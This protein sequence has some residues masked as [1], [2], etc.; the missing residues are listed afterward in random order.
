MDITQL[1]LDDHH[2]QRRQFAILEQIDRAA[3]AIETV[4]PERD[5]DAAAILT[6]HGS[7]GLEFPIVA[8]TGINTPPLAR[9]HVVW[10]ADG[11]PEITLYKEFTT[12]GFAAAQQAEKDLDQQEQLR[13]LYVGMTRAAD[14]LIVSIHHHPPQRG[15][16]DTHAMRLSQ[17][18]PV[19]EAAGAACE[20]AGRPVPAGVGSVLGSAAKYRLR[21][22]TMAPLCFTKIL[23]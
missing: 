9:G 20:P 4:T 1:I 11:P 13:L 7:K 23:I 18:L 19:L 3:D 2:E 6:I 22:R 12:P 16:P 8:L 15:G 14:H 5:D 10:P 17:M 21:A